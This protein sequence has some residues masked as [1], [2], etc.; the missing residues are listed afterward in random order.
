MHTIL[1]TGAAGFIGHKI[2]EFLLEQDHEVVGIDNLSP[3]YDLKIKACRLKD[4]A[5]HNQFHFEKIDVED[6]IRLSELFKKYSF[7]KV[8]H[9]AARGGVRNS[10][11]H[12]KEYVSTNV[13]GTVNI[14][15]QCKKHG[16]QN[17]V[18]AS[19]SSLYTGYEPPFREDLNVNMPS[20][21]YAAT[22]GAAELISHTYHH[23][24]SINV[25]VLRYFTVY[26]PLS[27][28]D[29]AQLRFLHRIANDQPIHINGDGTQSR[30]FTYVD[31]IA[32]GT[33]LASD[34]TGY[35]KFNMGRGAEPIKINT[36]I[37][38]IEK[39]LNKKAQRQY[40]EFNP[41]DIF[42]TYATNDKANAILGWQPEVSF[43]VGL[44]RC[45]EDYIHR[46]KFMGGLTI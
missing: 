4:L 1:V 6:E 45:V 39:K 7:K 27:R 43:E 38:L 36:M 11:E 34:C 30:D 3:Y 28:P 19:T 22:K 9:L 8:F 40:L 29:M 2:C 24:Y 46:K 14:L 32:K 44:Q 17:F 21:P 13:Q 12:P 20:S 10:I 5:P 41:A 15:E 31:D 33:I 18:L 42:K 23:L 35:N 26:G 37:D 16:V 25:A